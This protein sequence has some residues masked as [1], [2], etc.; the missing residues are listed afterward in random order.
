MHLESYKRAVNEKTQPINGDADFGVAATLVE[1][2]N[3][4]LLELEKPSSYSSVGLLGKN[5]C[6]KSHLLNMLLLLGE[7]SQNKYGKKR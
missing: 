4:F 7:M 5:G 6:G 3:M 2:I 1:Q